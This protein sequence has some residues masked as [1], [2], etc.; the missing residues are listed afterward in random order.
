M[1]FG[2][3]ISAAVVVVAAIALLPA[4]IEV[5]HY[6]Q[7]ALLMIDALGW[8]GFVLLVISLV[9]LLSLELRRARQALSVVL[10]YM[11]AQGF[12]WEG[13]Q[14]AP[15]H[16]NARFCA[17]YTIALALGAVPVLLGFEP[18][19]VT[20]VSLAL[21]SLTLPIAVVPFLF[22]MNDPTYLAQ[23]VNGWLS[24]AVVIVIIGMAFVLAVATIPL[25]IF[26][27]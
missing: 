20:T 16:R 21:T 10:A 19:Q 6:S 13:S 14:D 15:P 27:S 1:G 5:D 3:L 7:L 23:H 4:G 2:S 17:V 22:L 18:I 9:V 12:G 26:G 25:E 24:N 11:T 8:W